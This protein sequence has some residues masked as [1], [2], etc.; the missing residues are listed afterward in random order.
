[1]SAYVNFYSSLHFKSPCPDL[2]SMN[3]FKSSHWELLM[4]M[5]ACLH[6]DC[7]KQ[8]GFLHSFFAHVQQKVRQRNGCYPS[9]ICWAERVQL[10]PSAND[11]IHTLPPCGKLLHVH[12]LWPYSKTI[13]TQEPETIAVRQQRIMIQSLLV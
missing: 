1:M 5:V 13:P 4:T 3:V 2:C 8:L 10:T 7:V 6:N 9:H 11:F 12:F